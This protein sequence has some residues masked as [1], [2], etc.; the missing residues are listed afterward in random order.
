MGNPLR[1]ADEVRAGR[2][3]AFGE[4][5]QRFL[6]VLDDDRIL[7]AEKSLQDFL[8]LDS[9]AGRTFLDVGSGSGLFSLAARRLGATVVSFDNDPRSVAC[10]D[11]LRRRHFPGDPLWR[12]MLGSVLDAD[13]LESLGSFDVVYAWGVLHH[14][15]NLWRALENVTIATAAGSRLF[16]AIYNDGGRVSRRW[17]K[18]K[19]RYNRLPRV[20][21]LPYA[22]VVFAPVELALLGLFVMR[23]NARGYFSLWRNYKNSR[24]MSRQH[25]MIDWI[26]GYPYEFASIDQLLMFFGRT[27]FGVTRVVPN[28]GIGN[29]QIVLE[30]S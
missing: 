26:G 4:N 20:L 13:F 27:G 14:S 1:H 23:G 16:V 6:S 9:F 17:L 21:R 19:Q 5:W 28:G 2:R 24:G 22:F 30:R 18:R 12:V 11:A 7:E 29:H 10:T 3:F 15:G 25:D 8:G